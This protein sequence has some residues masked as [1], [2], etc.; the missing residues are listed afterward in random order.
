MKDVYFSGRNNNNNDDIDLTPEEI[1]LIRRRRMKKIRDLNNQNDDFIKKPADPKV[2]TADIPVIKN[3]YE[4][5]ERDYD[6][7]SQHYNSAKQK[8]A[9]QRTHNYETQ[10]DD[11]YYPDDDQYSNQ[12]K[13]TSNANNIR[14]KNK[15]CG[16]LAAMFV[17][18]FLVIVILIKVRRKIAISINNII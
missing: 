3:S 15:G 8:S 5:N 17:S 7:F 11:S 14:T 1:E 16:C 10:Y 2:D 9:Y 4:F 6:V 18:L 12:R 13:T